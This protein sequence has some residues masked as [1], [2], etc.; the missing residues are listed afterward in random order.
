EMVKRFNAAPGLIPELDQVL[1]NEQVVF[2]D[3]ANLS[4]R[5][6]VGA[7][8]TAVLVPMV[9]KDK[10]AAAVYVDAVSA[11]TGRFDRD[12]V[13]LLVF[14]TGLLVDTLAFRKKIP[15]PSLSESGTASPSSSPAELP[16]TAPQ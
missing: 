7:S 2:W 10:V 1:K 13:E 4:T 12:A 16:R 9:I 8:E 3:G 6:G 11:D 15:S 14:S 5:L